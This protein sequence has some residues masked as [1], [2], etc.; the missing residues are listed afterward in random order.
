MILKQFYLPCLAHASYLIGDETTGTAA[1]VDPQRDI[2][3][4]LSFATDHKLQIKHVILTHLHADFVA[5]HLELRD[6]VG[7]TIYLG[8]KAQAEYAFTPLSDGKVVE[9]GSVRLKALETPGHTPESISI[10]VYDLN[11]SETEPHAVLTGDTLFVG[12]VGR[13][14]LR[15]ALGWSATDLGALLFDS[16]QTKI[17]PLPDSSLVYPAHGAGSLCGKA[18]SK[19]TV[20]TIGEQRRLNY[21]LQPMS[22]KAFIELVTADQP[23]AP[24]YFVYDAVLNSKERATLDEALQRELKPIELDRVLELQAAGA[25]ILD[26][27]EP[28]EFATAH[29]AGS[30]NIGLSGQYATWAGT[31]LNRERAILI[32]ANPGR[33]SESAIRLGRIGFDNVAGYLRDGMR[34]LDSRPELT[35]SSE[36][37]SP[38]LAA[39]I[40]S[41]QEAPQLLDVRTPGERQQKAIEGSLSVPLN[42]LSERLQ[43]LQKGRPVLVYCAG[44]YRSSI[45]A[46]LLQQAGFRDVGEIAGGIAAWEL[47]KLPVSGGAA[48]VEKERV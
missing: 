20:S 3:I 26:T 14:D 34:S 6:Q 48:Q 8:A 27:R 45:A 1:V 16:L 39:E 47:A 22:K 33:E 10:A 13:P 24:P 30:T 38:A 43:E 23:E 32:I 15:A 41:S 31:I 11:K 44:G 37:Y 36:R 4:Y 17:L 35:K 7:A 9:F 21:A 19:E 28:E 40:L 5:G 12:D 2:G 25:Q 46:S 29:L 42:R 18:I